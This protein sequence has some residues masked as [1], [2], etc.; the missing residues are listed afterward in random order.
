LD[1][2]ID[3]VNLR[4]IKKELKIDAEIAFI[5]INDKEFSVFPIIY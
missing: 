2:E 4:F 5:E 1:S 3:I